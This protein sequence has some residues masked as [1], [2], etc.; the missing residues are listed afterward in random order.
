MR[1]EDMAI[2][3]SELLTARCGHLIPER[4]SRH[5]VA[6]LDMK[7]KEIKSSGKICDMQFMLRLSKT[8]R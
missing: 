2:D 3:R 7:A 1:I 4:E 8:L 5:P 6:D